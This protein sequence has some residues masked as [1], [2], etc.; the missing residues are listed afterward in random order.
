M[1]KNE[2]LRITPGDWKTRLKYDIYGAGY[3][4]GTTR[5]SDGAGNHYDEDNATLIADAGTTYNRTH[6]LPSVM[7]ERIRELEAELAEAYSLIVSVHKTLDLEN[8]E[9]YVNDDRSGAIDHADHDAHHKAAVLRPGSV[10]TSQ[11]RRRV[12]ALRHYRRVQ[13]PTWMRCIGRGAGSQQL[14]G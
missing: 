7:A 3:F 2:P 8:P 14:R 1:D 9:S 4:I 5:A 6:L 10:S 11:G 12:Q 13:L